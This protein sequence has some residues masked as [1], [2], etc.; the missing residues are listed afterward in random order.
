MIVFDLICGNGHKFEAWFRSSESY[1]QQKDADKIACPVC[2]DYAVEKAVMAPNIKPSSRRTAAGPQHEIQTVASPIDDKALPVL[3]DHIEA[4]LSEAVGK[5]KDHLE[6]NCDYVGD[7]FPE[8]AR[9]IHYGES[10]KR[11]IYGEASLAESAD[12]TEE[13]IEVVPLPFIGAKRTDA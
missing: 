5:V 11:S 12:L 1:G 6:K 10:E 8:E 13:G 3:P 9:K 4:Q 7:K 2:N